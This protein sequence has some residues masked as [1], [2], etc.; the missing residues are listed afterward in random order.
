[1]Q[2]K[3]EL[4]TNPE[5]G[6]K[7]SVQDDK[8]WFLCWCG[9]RYVPGRGN[10]GTCGDIVKHAKLQRGQRMQTAP[11]CQ[12]CGRIVPEN[13]DEKGRGRPRK[14]CS[15]SCKTMSCR[16]SRKDESTT[17]RSLRNSKGNAKEGS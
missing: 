15:D 8:G 17:S 10:G 9:N 5:D 14:Y 12:Y 4:D 16:G 6:L 3:K 1:M 11:R 13:P 7:P 2:A